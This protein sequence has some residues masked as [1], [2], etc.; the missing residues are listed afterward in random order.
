MTDKIKRNPI[1]DNSGFTLVEVIVALTILLMVIIPLATFYAVTLSTIQKSMLYSQA[2]QLCRERVEFCAGIEYDALRYWNPAFTPAFDMG[3]QINQNRDPDLSDDDDIFTYDP[4]VIAGSYNIPIYRDY[5][6]N[7][8]GRL[9]DPNYNG[10]CDDDLDGDGEYGVIDGDMDDIAIANPN[11]AM[12]TDNGVAVSDLPYFMQDFD[13]QYG[14][15][16]RAGDGLYDTVIE[17]IYANAFDPWLF[18]TRRLLRGDDDL[19][20]E[21]SPILDFSL[22][23]DPKQIGVLAGADYKHRE[24]TFRTFA[25]MTTT[26]SPRIVNS[27]NTSFNDF[28]VPL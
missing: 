27:L 8:T 21:V 12:W 9:I 6:D 5:Y 10:L 18:G 4:T 16:Q 19:R 7:S 24:Q 28:A 3:P 1:N 17:G 20:E 13:A 23:I 14:G 2:L 26:H 22:Q 25:R 11:G 15:L